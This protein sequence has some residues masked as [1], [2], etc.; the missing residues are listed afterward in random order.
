MHRGILEQKQRL[1]YRV[2]LNAE[3]GEMVVPDWFIS[4]SPST[5]SLNDASKTTYR[6]SVSIGTGIYEVTGDY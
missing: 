2:K 6:P 3:L 1:Y 5:Q 4:V